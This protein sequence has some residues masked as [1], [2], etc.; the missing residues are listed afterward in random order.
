MMQES[1]Q[2]A[3]LGKD[4]ELILPKSKLKNG[5][6]ASSY[7][8]LDG[9]TPMDSIV[10]KFRGLEFDVETLV[11]DYDRSI[12]P[13]IFAHPRSTEMARSHNDAFLVDAT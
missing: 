6:Q 5:R 7:K 10:K 2:E 9:R 8:A 3:Y 1:Q 12:S 4:S 13:L 11:N